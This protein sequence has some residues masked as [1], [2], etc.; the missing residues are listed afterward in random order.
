MSDNLGLLPFPDYPEMIAIRVVAFFA[1]TCLSPFWAKPFERER[2]KDAPSP[3]RG[4][5]SFGVKEIHELVLDQVAGKEGVLPF[6]CLENASDEAHFPY[7][8][9]YNLPFVFGSSTGDVSVG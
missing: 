7:P 1:K 9:S 3:V 5:G 2:K 6:P 8:H 4:A